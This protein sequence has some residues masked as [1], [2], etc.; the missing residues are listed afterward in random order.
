MAMMI[1]VP[2]VKS[3]RERLMRPGN[4]TAEAGAVNPSAD[5]C[6]GWPRHY[7]SDRNHG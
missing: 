6:R 4:V 1:P 2:R 7:G 5:R 3:S